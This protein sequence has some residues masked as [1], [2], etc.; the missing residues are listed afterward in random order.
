[1]S[2]RP[3]NYLWRKSSGGEPAT[4]IPTMTDWV[5][6]RPARCAR[7]RATIVRIQSRC[8]PPRIAPLANGNPASLARTS[9]PACPSLSRTGKA[10]VATPVTSRSAIP[11]RR[12]S[13]IGIRCS[14]STNRS[15]T[16][17]SCAPNAM[18]S[19]MDSASLGNNQSR[20][21]T[22][23]GS[24]LAV[25][26]HTTCRSSVPIA[27]MFKKVRAHRRT[28]PTLRWAARHVM[29]PAAWPSGKI[30]TRPHATMRSGCPGRW[31]MIFGPGRPTICRLGWIACAVII[32]KMTR[33]QSSPATFVAS[34]RCATPMGWNSVR[35]GSCASLAVVTPPPRPR[36][37][38]RVKHRT[39]SRFR[40]HNLTISRCEVKTLSQM[41][42]RCDREPGWSA[43]GQIGTENTS[44]L[45]GQC[46]ARAIHLEPDGQNC[47]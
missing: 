27:T 17:P 20:R 19:N 42:R 46:C 21:R 38:Q 11:T 29:M 22:K 40:S 30:R 12:R 35:G 10:S 6:T 9:K 26:E 43:R 3:M 1:M 45:N 15:R 28:W 7:P 47:Q 13:R 31:R 33:G 25:T 18:P 23:A 34:T 39:S 24:A 4:P 32:R 5:R 2:P 37:G 36:P 41:W 14:N 16:A 8:K 44:S